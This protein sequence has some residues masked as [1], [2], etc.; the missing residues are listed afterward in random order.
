M[1]LLRRI[2]PQ[3]A[4]SPT[5]DLCKSNESSRIVNN[6]TPYIIQVTEKPLD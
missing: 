6:L 4:Q 3:S 1:I 5:G 2:R